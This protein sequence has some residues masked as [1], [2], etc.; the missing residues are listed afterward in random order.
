LQIANHTTIH[1]KKSV[2][3]HDKIEN[4]YMV[5]NMAIVKKKKKRID[6]KENPSGKNSIFL[7]FG[8]NRI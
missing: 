4:K 1:A 5:S 7:L 3:S 6:F 2:S 8:E